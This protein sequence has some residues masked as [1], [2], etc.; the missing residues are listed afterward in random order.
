MMR[1]FYLAR[2]EDPSGISGCGRV[3]DGVQFG[4][5]TCILRWLGP[6]P[7]T[8]VWPGIEPMLKTHGHG[9]K[10]TVVWLDTEPG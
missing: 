10:T 3:A 4:D 1:R 7:A 6:F 9:G 5:G 8:A 2:S